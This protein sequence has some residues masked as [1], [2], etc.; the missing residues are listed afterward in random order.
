MT[1]MIGGLP[2]ARQGDMVVEVGVPNAIVMGA[3]TVMIG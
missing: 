2:A 1:V 3:P